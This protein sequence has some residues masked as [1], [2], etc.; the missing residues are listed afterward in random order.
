MILDYKVPYGPGMQSHADQEELY[1][2]LHHSNIC[3]AII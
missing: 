2:R 3:Y 1:M